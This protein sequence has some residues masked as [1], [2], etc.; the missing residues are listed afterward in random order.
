MDAAAA[1]DAAAICSGSGAPALPPAPDAGG[2]AA[3][4]AAPHTWSLQDILWSPHDMVRA[5]WRR[6]SAHAP[7]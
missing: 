3:V 2:W 6:V 7:P 5:A 1:W 4:A